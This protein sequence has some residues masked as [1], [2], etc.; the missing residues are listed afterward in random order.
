MP[1]ITAYVAIGSNI[2]PELHVPEALRYLCREAHLSGISTTYR[3]APIRHG[4]NQGDFLNGVWR[5][6]TEK[7]PRE[8]KDS[9]REIESIFGRVRQADPYA[10]RTLDL[11]LLMWSDLV[12]SGL[13]IPDEDILKRSFLFGPLI[14]LDEKLIWPLTCRP[15]KD[16]VDISQIPLLQADEEMTLLLKGIINE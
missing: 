13:G 11:D 3:T 4:G 16:M 12:D 14:E 7:T 2:E 1:V 8:L 15:L 6:E 5:I 10:P 9:F